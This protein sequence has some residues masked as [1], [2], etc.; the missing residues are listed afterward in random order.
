MIVGVGVTPNTNL[1][2]RAGIELGPTDPDLLGLDEDEFVDRLVDNAPDKPPNYERVIEI[3][4]GSE[5]P[6]DESE[7]TELELGPNNCAA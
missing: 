7:A 5:P 4:T 6:E 1:A 2:E 3:N